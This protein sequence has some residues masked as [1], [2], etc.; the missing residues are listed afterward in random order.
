MA[1]KKRVQSIKNIL[2]KIPYS[3][4]LYWYLQ[5]PEG[6]P[7]GSFSLKRVEKHINQWHKEATDARR[8][9]HPGKD[10][11]IF[12]AF[13]SWMRQISLTGL[14]LVGLGHNVVWGYLPYTTWQEEET[15]FDLRRQDK[16]INQ[17][18]EPATSSL[19]L[20]SMQN[21]GTDKYLPSEL[22][23]KMQALAYR[24]VKYSLLREDVEKDSDLY[25]LR[26]K[27]NTALAKSALTWLKKN[28]PDVVIIPNGSVLE[29]GAVFHVARYLE[30]KVV[31]YEFGEKREHMWLAQ[32]R[33][34]M[35]QETDQM[36][37][38]YKNKTLTE[39]ERERI[40]NLFAARQ[41]AD[42]WKNFARQ[43]QKT[44]SQGGE[45]V[46]NTL[47]LD[48]RP[49]V[50]LPTNVLGDSL[51]LGRQIFSDGMTEWLIR[52]IQYFIEHPEF[53]L[54]IRIHPGEQLSWGPSAFDIVNDYFIELPEN[55]HLLPSD[56]S[57]N[58]YDL[59]EIATLA[60]VF[61]TTLG[62]EIA[63]SG[64]PVI[65]VGETH[66][67]GK[68]FTLDATTWEEYFQFLRDTLASPSETRLSKEEIEQTW[69]YAYRFFFNFP[70]PYPWHGHDLWK[71][72]K[73]YSLAWVL[74][75][76]G[77]DKF[78]DTFRYLVGE[79]IEW[80]KS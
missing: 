26:L 10:V 36:W 37:A 3:A 58:S 2:G 54:V 65:V 7:P 57:V 67:R 17:V 76:E 66:Y 78:G 23:Q 34:I 45:E 63:M 47:G 20:V 29:F 75:E 18:L 13:S 48:Q 21:I 51:T 42:V 59:A 64:L 44:S 68:G 70:F 39:E 8:T 56:A 31:T 71:D 43:W 72:V 25:R 49:I 12:S 38:A 61:T 79:P 14:A 74:S 69:T 16:Y 27:R 9:A 22:M 40:H 1:D 30:L 5:Q 55:I 80:K 24:D 77:L 60:T 62:M 15:E 52:T 50:F 73:K 46:R 11:F 28:R 41:G 53:Q 35:R 4:D 32:D 33:D 19:Q 6:P